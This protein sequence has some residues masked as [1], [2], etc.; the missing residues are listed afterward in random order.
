MVTETLNI[1][2]KENYALVKLSRGKA[3]PV[4]HQMVKDLS[5]TF[6]SLQE[7]AEMKGVILTGTPNFFSAGLDV[8]EL[9]DY[10][11]DQMR[12]F[13]IDFGAMH[14]QLSRFP[15]PMICAIPGYC[16]AGGTVIAIAADYR[17]MNEDPKFSIGLNEM[18]VN[19]Q[20]TTNLIEAY[21][22]WLGT[23]LANRYILEGKLLTPS[24]ALKVNLVD[25]I[26]PADEVMVRAELKLQEFLQA[27]SDIFGYT[28]SKLRKKWYAG[29]ELRG[30]ADLEQILKVWWKPEIRTK[31]ASLIAS[32][33]NKKNE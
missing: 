26:C 16:P 29:Q 11:E 10:D 12:S 25:E 13:M 31:I 7:E 1:T 18:K 2:R 20:I 27:D 19:V 24:E 28:K 4:N 3:N 23:S 32:F 30:G 33:K 5:A 14:V 8:V 15:K 21:S 6:K 22:Y 17:V 9:Y